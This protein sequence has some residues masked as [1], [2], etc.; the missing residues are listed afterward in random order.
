[1]VSSDHRAYSNNDSISDSTSHAI[2][3]DDFTRSRNLVIGYFTDIIIA[4]ITT[5]QRNRC[6]AEIGPH[7]QNPLY[8][9]LCD[10]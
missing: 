3:H 8:R 2:A 1:M 10:F 9:N 7:R 4:D 6:F 5:G